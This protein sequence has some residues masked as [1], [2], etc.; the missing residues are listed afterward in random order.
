V[1]ALNAGA[2]T[3]ECSFSCTDIYSALY[4]TSARPGYVLEAQGDGPG[5]AGQPVILA[6]AS[7][8]N[9]AE[10]FEVGPVQLVSDLY[11]AGLVSF[12]VA[13]RYGCLAGVIAEA[14]PAGAVN[15]YAVE[16]E[17]APYG[18][19]T[20]LCGGVATPPAD[21]TPVTLQPCGVSGKTFWIINPVKPLP[22]PPTGVPT[23]PTCGLDAFNGLASLISAADST[24]YA[25]STSF[26]PG[27]PLFTYT[28]IKNFKYQLWGAN[29]GEIG[30]ICTTGPSVKPT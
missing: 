8:S 12:G 14:C 26:N 22:T 18:A 5:R 16:I 29:E 27:A 4:G 17:Y 7:V 6:R 2:A 30:A 21:T 28:L 3:P 13:L 23:G 19:P 24:P 20:G 9:P 11:Q 1:V 10:D 15:D 25:L